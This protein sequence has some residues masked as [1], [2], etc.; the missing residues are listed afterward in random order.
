[1]KSGNFHFLD[2]VLKEW[3]LFA[4]AAGLFA[5]S[6]YLKRIPRYSRDEFEV[7]FLL[8]SLFM[9]VKG[10]EESGLMSRFSQ[11]LECG[12]LLPLKLVMATFILSMVVTNDVSLVMVVP[13]TLMLNLPRKGMVVILEAL[14]ANAG[15][16]LTPFGNPQNLFIY[17]RYHI[18]PL[19]FIL[20]MLPFAFFFGALLGVGALFLGGRSRA[21]EGRST[22]VVSKK[23][24]IYGIFLLIMVLT[25]FHMVPLWLGI[26]VILYAALFDRRSLKIDYMLL[27]TFFCFFG[28]ADNFKVML[29][30]LIARSKNTFLLSA[31]VSQVISNVPAAIL[32]ADFTT[33]WKALLWGTNVGGF[34][35]LVGSLANLIAYKFY[36][37]EEKN[38]H[39]LGFTLQFLLLGYLAFFLGTLLYMLLF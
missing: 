12:S 14:A 2:F 20:T 18:D 33:K 3:L 25:V 30:S 5:T 11:W 34:G 7:L 1:M 19:R 21:C 13:L 15:S 6:L 36:V 31:L 10:L 28:L 27:L 26:G 24:F 4:A 8:A 16:A 32:L 9:A 35:S 37:A 17:W 38:S 22:V 39:L 23:A 29:P